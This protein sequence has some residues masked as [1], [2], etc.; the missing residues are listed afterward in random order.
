M[1]YS[2]KCSVK[3]MR[4]HSLS[5]NLF[6]NKIHE[7]VKFITVVCYICTRS[8]APIMLEFCV[9]PSPLRPIASLQL[10]FSI[11]ALSLT[12]ELG[13]RYRSG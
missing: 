8:H 11:P 2:P 9:Y 12:T 7:D 1:I 6:H 4:V 10:F 5:G 13:P 3:Q